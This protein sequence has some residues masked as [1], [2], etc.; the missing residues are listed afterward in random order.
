MLLTDA[1][2]EGDSPEPAISFTEEGKK[3]V[4]GAC[5]YISSNIP[6]LKLCETNLSVSGESL[7]T[8]YKSPL[9]S[10]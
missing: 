6:V 4:Q 2:K 5:Q 1:G 10:F 7:L 9:K 8:S 3:E